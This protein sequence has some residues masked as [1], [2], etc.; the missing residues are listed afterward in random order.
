MLLKGRF[1]VFC[2]DFIDK[3]K[4]ISILKCLINIFN[5]S[6]SFTNLHTKPAGW[7]SVFGCCLNKYHFVRFLV[8]KMSANSTVEKFLYKMKEYGPNIIFCS[9]IFVATDRVIILLLISYKIWN[10]ND[11]IRGKKGQTKKVTE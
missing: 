7:I 2:T 1:C 4:H 9:N 11:F 8:T 6:W 5:R 10:Q 3:S